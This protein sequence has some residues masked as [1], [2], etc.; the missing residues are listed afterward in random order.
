MDAAK[1]IKKTIRRQKIRKKIMTMMTRVEDC[2]NLSLKICK[3]G[4]KEEG[5]YPLIE[6]TITFNLQHFISLILVS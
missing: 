3:A 6:D 4:F 2:L 5:Q 1:T